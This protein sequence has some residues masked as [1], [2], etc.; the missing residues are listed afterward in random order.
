MKQIL[1]LLIS[2]SVANMALSQSVTLEDARKIYS[3]SMDNK[4]TCE[5]AY[6]KF[7]T[8][9]N[10]GNPLLTGYKGAIAVAMSKHGKGAKEKLGYFN[11]GK[12]LIESSV[13]EDSKNVE[14]RFVRF[15]IQTNVPP[16]L[17]YN[18]EIAADKKFI[19]ENLTG[20]KNSGV[21]SR[22]KDYLLQSK[23]VSTEEKQKINAL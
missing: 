17:K 5:A 1:F 20:V 10:T 2:L 9:K 16:A 21:R 15:T 4:A 22:I 12:K 13:L 23:D 19:I 6:Q 11:E 18:K 7:S 14:L 8:V 3:E